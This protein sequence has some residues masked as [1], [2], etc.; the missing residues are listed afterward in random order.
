MSVKVS[1]SSPIQRGKTEIKEI[2]ITEAMR[3][4]GC[5]RGLKLYDVLQ[6]DVD[7]LFKLLPRV[8]EPALMEVEIVSMN[9]ADFVALATAVT[10]FLTPTSAGSAT[11]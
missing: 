3:Q 8:T 7:S 2:T 4:P 10:G 5:L 11:E 6:S 9:N 1:L